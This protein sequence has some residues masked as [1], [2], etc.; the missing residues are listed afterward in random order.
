MWTADQLEELEE[1]DPAA[2]ARLM[3]HARQNA[4]R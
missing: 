3:A 2:H 4:V 1:R